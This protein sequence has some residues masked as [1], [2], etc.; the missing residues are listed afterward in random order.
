[1]QIGRHAGASMPFLGPCAGP[2]KRSSQNFRAHAFS[3]HLRSRSVARSL[4]SQPPNP[5]PLGW[6]S[7]SRHLGQGG[8]TALA[9]QVSSNDFK[10]GMTIEFDG[11]PYRVMEFLHVKPGK[12]AAFVRSKLKNYLTGNTTERTWRAG[13]TVEIAQIEKK[14]TQFTYTDGTDFV[15]MDMSSYEEIRVQKD[16]TW[17]KYLTEGASVSLVLWNGTVISVDPP[18]TVELQ[19]VE[20]DPGVKGNTAQGGSKPAT[21]ETGAVISVPLFVQSGERINVDTQSGTYVGRASS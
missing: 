19:I 13:E 2:L 18:A 11:S 3:Q 12:G 20:T 10:T 7:P 8:G 21:L 9:A 1:M 17:A 6:P 14:D 15:F 16:P 4:H 5:M